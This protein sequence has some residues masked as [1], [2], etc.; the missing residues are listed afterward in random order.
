MTATHTSIAEWIAKSAMPFDVD[1]P[2][3]IDAAGDG[4]WY[5]QNIHWVGETLQAVHDWDSV[6]SQPEAAIAGHAAAVW[7]GTGG[8]GEV[9]SIGQTEQ[10]LDGYADAR[11]RPWSRDELEAA[12]AAGLWNRAFDAKKA[13]LVGDD[14]DLILTR[15]EG[16]ERARRAGLRS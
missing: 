6:V 13:G 3:S 8:P 16:A 4:D 5:S 9:A 14:T 1:L 10:F 7:P 15:S 12:W 11:G 2:G